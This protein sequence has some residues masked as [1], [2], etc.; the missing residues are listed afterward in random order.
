MEHECEY[1]SICCEVGVAEDTELDYG[2]KQNDLM[3]GICGSCHD[4]TIFE[5]ITCEEE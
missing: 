2:G 4:H 1:T 3:V 5:C